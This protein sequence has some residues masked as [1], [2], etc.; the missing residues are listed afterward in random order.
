MHRSEYLRPCCKPWDFIS[1]N[2]VSAEQEK[3]SYFFG[4][5]TAT[6]KGDLRATV[7]A[8]GVKGFLSKNE[9]TKLLATNQEIRLGQLQGWWIGIKMSLTF[10]FGRSALTLAYLTPHALGTLSGTFIFL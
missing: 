1:S 4:A 6:L 8:Q 9:W 5:L 10:L 3:Q 7:V 2:I